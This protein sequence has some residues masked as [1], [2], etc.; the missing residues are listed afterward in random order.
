M[1]IA[2]ITDEAIA[3]SYRNADPDWLR[4]AFTEGIQLAMDDDE[5]T[6]DDLWERM[7]EHHPDVKTHDHRAMGAVMRKLKAEQAIRPTTLYRQSRRPSRHGA[8]IRVW[9]SML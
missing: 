7:E 6:S 9:R 5:I 4:I 1:K 8:P 2:E 3:R